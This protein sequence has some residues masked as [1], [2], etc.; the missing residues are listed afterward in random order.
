MN[1][2]TLLYKITQSFASIS[3]RPFLFAITALVELIILYFILY[4][5]NLFHISDNYPALSAISILGLTFVQ[6][7]NY[8]FVRNAAQIRA[9]GANPPLSL[10]KFTLK[11]IATIASIFII[12]IAIKYFLLLFLS[13]PALHT[14]LQYTINV[15]ITIGIIYLIYL[16]LKPTIKLSKTN[17]LGKPILYISRIFD[18]IKYQYSITTNTTWIILLVT[19]LLIGLKFL[20]PTIINKLNNSNSTQLLGLPVYLNNEHN[21]GH[22]KLLNP[23]GKRHYE[24]SISCWFWITPQPPNTRKSY[25]KFTNIISYAGRPAVEYKSI[26]NTLRITYKLSPGRTANIYETTKIPMQRWNYMVLNFDKG[27]MDVFI[28]GELVASRPDIA[29]YL[30]YENITAGADKGLEGGVCNVMY[31]NSILQANAI[32]NTY[33]IL[34]SL[35]TPILQA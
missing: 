22:F 11:I 12:I 1:E 31:S 6:L 16:L 34:G 33:K 17:L 25:T 21:L 28:N 5:W 2:S 8:F 9:D 27:T 23:K 13:F 30:S 26:D 24:Y 15:L 18:W 19:S 7:M 32:Q 4:K 20:F 10:S 3:K 35:R 29:P 14:M